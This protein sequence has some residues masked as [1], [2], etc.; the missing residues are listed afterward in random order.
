MAPAARGVHARRGERGAGVKLG[1]LDL[2]FNFIA[3]GRGESAKR[4]PRADRRNC[5]TRE[6]L[7]EASRK[8]LQRDSAGALRRASAG[9][10]KWLRGVYEIY[11]GL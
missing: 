6:R 11:K 3:R 8:E 4:A 7:R 10:A 1:A 9:A 2:D 5:E